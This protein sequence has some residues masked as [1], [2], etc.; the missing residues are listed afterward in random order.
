MPSYQADVVPILQRACIPCHSATGIAGY[1][2]STYAKVYPQR[3][4]IL[5]QVNACLMPPAGSPQLTT[6]ERIALLGWLVCNAPN[7]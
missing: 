6:Q 3:S 5:D 7:D 2:E 4:A 1:D